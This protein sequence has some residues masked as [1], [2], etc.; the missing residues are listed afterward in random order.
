M[1]LIKQI[2]YIYYDTLILQYNGYYQIIRE[3]LSWGSPHRHHPPT[4]TLD[5]YSK[6]NIAYDMKA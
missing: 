4:P 6:K 1:K 3:Q 2:I 5:Y